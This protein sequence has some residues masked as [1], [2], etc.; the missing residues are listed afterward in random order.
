MAKVLIN[1]GTTANDGTGDNLRA[2][3]NKV[4]L[5]F[6]EIYSAIGDGSTL[7]ANIK[8]KD[9]SST[10]ATINAKG[11]V[12]GILGGTGIGST[13]SGN[14]VT[15]AIDGTVVTDSST[16]TLTNKTINGSNNTL[17]NIANSSLVYNSVTFSDGSATDAVALGETVTISGTANEIES[18]VT[19]NTVTLGLPNNV[20]ISN[21]LTVLGDLDVQGTQTVIDSATIQI[22]NSFTF[23]GTTS[24]DFETV[25][26]VIDPTADRTVSLPNATGTIVLQD[27]TDT[28]TNKT[29]TSPVLGGITSSA[30]GNIALQP[31]TNILEIMGDG[32]TVDAA[33]RLNCYTNTHGQ[34]LKSQPHSEAVTNTMLLPK[35]SNST[36]VSEVA[37]QTL[38][39]KT[40]D[41]TTD[42]NK[43][44]ANFAG[45]GAFPDSTTYEGAFVYDTTG[46]KPYVLDTGGA[47]NILTENDSVS[48]H[49]DVNISGI[50]NNQALVW[51]SAQAR[52]NA[53]AIPTAGFSIAMA[54]A[55]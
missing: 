25:L 14:N 38:T 32:A 44:R 46:D 2:G 53:A 16:N 20:T 11:D 45:T 51:N 28:L 39:N 7:S 26:T 50:A 3:A 17:S 42:G 15:L 41:L 30:S 34:T 6:D 43:V 33:I 35:G 12:L 4:N 22:T 54:V 19:A 48:R 29:L 5:N 18:A 36:L 47:V 40:L 10:L 37:T 1:R 21:N 27:T 55:L 31:A 8:V 13:V 49:A 52:F 23:E 9:D 24:D